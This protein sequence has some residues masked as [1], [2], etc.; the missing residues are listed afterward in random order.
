MEQS[1]REQARE[2]R[3]RGDGG[4]ARRGWDAESVRN[5]K[6]RCMCKAHLCGHKLARLSVLRPLLSKGPRRRPESGPW[7][8]GRGLQGQFAKRWWS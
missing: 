3:M 1:G 6:T 4:W 2:V 7:H 8:D 5:R